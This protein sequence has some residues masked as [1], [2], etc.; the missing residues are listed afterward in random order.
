MPVKIEARQDN[1]VVEICVL[2]FNSEENFV[3]T[4]K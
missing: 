1:H 3:F 4:V 2:T